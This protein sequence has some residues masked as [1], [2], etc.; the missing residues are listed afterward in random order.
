MCQ[1]TVSSPSTCGRGNGDG[2][3]DTTELPFY[4]H[5]F[6]GGFG[7]VRGFEANTWARSTPPILYQTGLATTG[8]DEEVCQLKSVGLMVLALA[9]S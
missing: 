8:V 4:E 7:S 6:S 2:Y 9:I 3:G 1:F 5:F